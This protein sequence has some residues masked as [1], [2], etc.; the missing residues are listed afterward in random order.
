M[1][2]ED[3]HAPGVKSSS[4]PNPQLTGW[5]YFESLLG[6][7]DRVEAHQQYLKAQRADN[8]DICMIHLDSGGGIPGDL[9]EA[10]YVSRKQH[11]ASEHFPR[12]WAEYDERVTQRNAAATNYSNA[13]NSRQEGSE[14]WQQLVH[15]NTD[16]T[17][18]ERIMSRLLIE[19][20]LVKTQSRQTMSPKMTDQKSIHQWKGMI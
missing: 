7:A 10:C 15:L 1:A 5:A 16:L 6:Q 8:A 17:E 9:R 18:R 4:A 13:V 20:G 2:S 12:R 11:D 19:S 14:F 3:V